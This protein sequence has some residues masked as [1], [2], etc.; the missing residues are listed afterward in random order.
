MKSK[1]VFHPVFFLVLC[2]SLF[3]FQAVFSQEMQSG[4]IIGKIMDDRG[5]PLPGVSITVTGPALQGRMS[6]V[7]NPEG[8]Y[9]VVG[10]PPGSDYEVRAELAGFETVI[11]KGII[12]RVG[13]TVVIDLQIMPSEVKEEIEVIAASP[14][15]DV[16]RSTKS[17]V[18][19]S[20]ILV[21]LPL[22][23]RFANLMTVVAGAIGESIYGGGRGEMESVIE[24][25]HQDSAASGE[26]TIGGDTEMAWHLVEEVEVIAAGSSAEHYGSATGKAI[27]VMKSGGNRL[28]GDFSLYYTNRNLVNVRLPEPDLA[29]LNLAKPSTPVY[30]YDASA[31]LGGAIIKDRLWYM[32]GF[33][34]LNTKYEGGFRPTVILG[35]QYDN[36]DRFVYDYIGYL[37][38]TFQLADNL[39]GSLMGHY[40]MKDGPYW[41]SAWY[42]TNEGNAHIRPTRLHWSGNL[43]WFID[44]NTILNLKAGGPQAWWFCRPTKEANPDGPIFVDD[45]TGYRW[46]TEVNGDAREFAY[47][48]S[49]SLTKFVDNLL[50][51][52]HEFKAGVEWEYGSNRESYYLKQPLVWYYYDGSP[53]YWRAQNYGVRDPLYG[54]GLLTYMVWGKS[55]WETDSYGI[56]SRIGGFIQ[57]S[58]KIKRLTLNAGVR[59]DYIESWVPGRTKGASGDPVALAIGEYYFKPVYGLNPYDEIPYPTWKN[60]FPFGV[61]VSPR[62]GLTYDLF[63]NHKTA[64]K[65]SFSHIALPYGTY[66]YSDAYPLSPWRSFTFNWWDLNENGIPDPPPIDHYEEAYGENPLDMISD[67]YLKAIDPNIKPPYMDELNF[68]IEHE[69]LSDFQLSVHYILRKRGNIMGNV[70]W[71]ENTGRY[72]YTYEKAPEWWVP[73]STVV[74]AYGIF[75]AKEIT[76]YFLSKDAPDQFSRMTN[77]PEASW[78]YRS[79]EIAFNKRMSHGWQLG[80]SVNFSKNKGN[81]RLDYAAAWNFS[82]YYSPNS[83]VNAYGELPYS[84]PVIIKLYG[85]FHLP[86][87]I[88]FSFIFQHIDGSPWGR[89]VTVLPPADWA[90]EHNAYTYG[91]TVYV[92]PPGTR[93]N[94]AYDT[95]DMRLQTDFNIGPGLFGFYIDVFNLLGAYTLTVSNNPAGTWRPVAEGS[96]E[97]SYT[98]GSLGLRGFSGFRQIRFSI[99]YR[100]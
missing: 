60:A 61:F 30:N 81:Y 98:P 26:T 87:Q 100:F 43:F 45:Y 19:T 54:D 11:R 46:G 94:E 41:S 99:L 36:Y 44:S 76:M 49:I 37:K 70:L 28:T 68:G 85:T 12:I 1:I 93:R 79:L 80:G 52:E 96:A 92:E 89:T 14:T 13:G 88:M 71:D 42:I 2:F 34:Y 4:R 97:G 51:G 21:S 72:W 24:G 32:I 90:E 10:L 3:V 73:F 22:G 56:H 75:P 17:T 33:R 67:A 58:Y 38:L 95:L 83:F 29:T 65:A 66:H 8:V 63:G 84:R 23:R 55:K 77:I 18:V 50:G 15:V 40:A 64:L 25:V 39:R 7:T 48:I 86:Y 59:F 20:D 27:M 74:P 91:Y 62:I 9:R 16:V 47:N 57:D 35:K 31:A 6:A 5:D 69:L 53:Y 82:D 78:K